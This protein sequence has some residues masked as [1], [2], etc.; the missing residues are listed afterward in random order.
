[1]ASNYEHRR[2]NDQ[3][4]GWR[5]VSVPANA[6]HTGGSASGNPQATIA[7]GFR[8][9][10][11]ER[12][13]YIEGQTTTP[14]W[15]APHCED[16]VPI[17]KPTPCRPCSTHHVYGDATA[18]HARSPGPFQPRS[19]EVHEV[20]QNTPMAGGDAPNSRTRGTPTTMDPIVPIGGVTL[21]TRHFKGYREAGQ[22][23]VGGETAPP[24]EVFI[25]GRPPSAAS[26][27]PAYPRSENIP[28]A[29]APSVR[30]T[31]AL[32]DQ[33]QIRQIMTEIRDE[34]SQST[35]GEA[36]LGVM[37]YWARGGQPDPYPCTDPASGLTGE[38]G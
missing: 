28:A 27:Q 11:D 2:I 4:A 33:Q 30:P 36:G 19:V 25:G 20:Y 16:K 12:R 7:P 10:R 17:G 31:S 13:H 22:M 9:P 34:K 32:P 18:Y 1:M 3:S 26:P 23:G 5:T 6:P 14:K 8:P 35:T 24:S 38:P 21:Q 29:G 37:A 15:D